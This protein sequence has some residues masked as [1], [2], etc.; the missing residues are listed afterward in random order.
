[1]PTPSCVGP[2][3]RD[4][5]RFGAVS[6]ATAGA[7][8]VRPFRLRAESGDPRASNLPAVI[9]VWLPGGPAHQDTSA[10]TRRTRRLRS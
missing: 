7:L 9:S 8:G 3:R 6:L 4:A 10:A 2:S 5:L 1:M